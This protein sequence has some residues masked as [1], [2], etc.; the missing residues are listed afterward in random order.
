VQTLTVQD[1]RLQCRMFPYSAGPY[2]A[3]CS[4]TVQDVCLKCRPL[5]CRM[6]PYSAGCSLQCRPL[7]RRPIQCRM[8]P[9]SAGCSLKVQALTVQDVPLQC[10]MFLTVQALTVLRIAAM[11]ISWQSLGHAPLT[12]K[13]KQRAKERRISSTGEHS[14]LTYTCVSVCVCVCMCVCVCVWER[15][16]EIVCCVCY[17]QT[18]LHGKDAI[19]AFGTH[20]KVPQ[21]WSRFPSLTLWSSKRH[22][23]KCKKHHWHF[24]QEEGTSANA[25][26]ITDTLNK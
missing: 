16:R 17:L 20:P 4:L 5:Q 18:W 22:A 7:Q 9:Y 23:C 2:S 11:E 19:P 1:V 24:G 3:G 25:T 8:F 15:E 12:R 14:N 10:R 13:S 6:F 21:K 26:N